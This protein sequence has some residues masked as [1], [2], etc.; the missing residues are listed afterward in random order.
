MNENNIEADE[1]CK[2]CGCIIDSCGY[3]TDVDCLYGDYLQD[4]EPDE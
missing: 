2:E 3:C 4:E 1:E